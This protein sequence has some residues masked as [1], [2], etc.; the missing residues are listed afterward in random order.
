M[1]LFYQLENCEVTSLERV[2]LWN[3]K[4][5]IKNSLS[6]HFFILMYNIDEKG[7]KVLLEM[8]GSVYIFETQIN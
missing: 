1:W 6:S 7:N 8:E 3:H 5:E 2:A 4:L